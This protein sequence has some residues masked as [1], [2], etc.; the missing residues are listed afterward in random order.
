LSTMIARVDNIIVQLKT[1]RKWNWH[2]ILNARMLLLW[3]Y[4]QP[5]LLLWLRVLGDWG[6]FSRRNWSSICFWLLFV[7]ISHENVDGDWFG[8]CRM[9]IDII[10]MFN[11]KENTKTTLILWK[12]FHR[13][14]VC[15]RRKFVFEHGPLRKEFFYSISRMIF[16]FSLSTVV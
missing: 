5:M 8:K 4:S 9:F 6:R 14:H 13:E 2:S 1:N 16:D 7:Q 3:A 11:S 10:N 12:W 15:L